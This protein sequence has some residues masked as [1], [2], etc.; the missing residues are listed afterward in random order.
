MGERS[1]LVV[2]KSAVSFV[3]SACVMVRRAAFGDGFNEDL[4][5]GED[6]DFVWRLADQGWL[7]RYDSQV[8]VRHRTRA[9]GVA[10][11]RQRASYGASTA[12]LAK[13]HGARLAPLRVDTW[14]LVAWTSV[15]IGQPAFGARIVRGARNHARDHFFVAEDDP[16]TAPTRWSYETWCARVDR[17]RARWCGPLALASCSRRC[18]PNFARARWLLFAIGSLWRWRGS[19]GAST[20]PA[21]RGRRRPRLRRRRARRSVAREDRDRADARRYEVR[22]RAERDSGHSPAPRAPRFPARGVRAP[23]PRRR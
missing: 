9:V 15:L 14:T 5:V 22:A 7:V 21:L 17:W 1:G 13:R 4:R 6:V 20:R 8:V 19:A 16:N 11:W 18:T 12:A 23:A 2:A 3:P 10:W